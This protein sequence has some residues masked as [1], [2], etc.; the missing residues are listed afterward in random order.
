MNDSTTPSDE[1]VRSNSVE[2]VVAVLLLRVRRA[3]E[4]RLDQGLLVIGGQM[5]A[6]ARELATTVERVREDAL[7]ARIVESLGQELQEGLDRDEWIADL[8]DDLG[9]ESAESRESV[10]LAHGAVELGHAV[11]RHA[12]SKSVREL[13]GDFRQN[14]DRARPQRSARLDGIDQK[15]RGRHRAESRDRRCR[16]HTAGS[17]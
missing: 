3:S 8:V 12:R 17:E 14:R 5:D 16:S 9:Y 10:D 1:G 2:A 4:R 15:D 6:L 7:R 11:E 13:R